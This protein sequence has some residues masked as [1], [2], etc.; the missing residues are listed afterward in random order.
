MSFV[1]IF[2]LTEY[3]HSSKWS[4]GVTITSLGCYITFVE[5]VFVTGVSGRL[6]SKFDR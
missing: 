3:G 4:W 6:Y 1:S 5:Y 2:T